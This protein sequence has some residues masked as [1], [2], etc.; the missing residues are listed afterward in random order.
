MPRGRIGG[1]ASPTT[2]EL[3]ERRLL[4]EEADEELREALA[5]A[6]FAIEGFVHVLSD[7]YVP[8]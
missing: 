5:G 7:G 3:L 4:V 2:E 8:G 6:S 1:R